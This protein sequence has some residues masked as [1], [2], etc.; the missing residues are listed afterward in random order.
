M[1]EIAHHDKLGRLIAVDDYVA[2]PFCN[3][4]EFGR[5][6]KLNKVM[7]GVVP[8]IGGPHRGKN[9]NK[10]P[11]DMVRLESAEVTWYLLKHTK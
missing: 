6:K 5:V 10:Y 1:K 7:I 4:L 8:I 11:D 2:F 3:S 9:I